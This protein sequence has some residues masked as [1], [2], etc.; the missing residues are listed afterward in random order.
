MEMKTWQKGE[1]AV[2]MFIRR[3][4]EKGITVSRPVS[5]CCRYDAIID[6][7]GV[8]MRVQIK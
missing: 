1:V 6:V 8:L 4:V 3:C 2:S 5:E 7:D